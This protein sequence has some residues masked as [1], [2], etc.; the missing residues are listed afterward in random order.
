MGC[1][2]LKTYIFHDHSHKPGTG[3]ALKNCNGLTILKFIFCFVQVLPL[4]IIY[5][6]IDF[7]FKDH[8]TMKKP[9]KKGEKHAAEIDPKPAKGP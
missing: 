6:Y 9:N 3:K 2:A 1:Q 4:Q 7:I 8:Y 5:I